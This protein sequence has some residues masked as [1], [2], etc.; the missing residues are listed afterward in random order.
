MDNTGSA[1]ERTRALGALGMLGMEKNE[2]K[3]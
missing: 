3:D 1:K 2:Q